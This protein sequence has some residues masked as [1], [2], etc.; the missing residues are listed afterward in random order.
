MLPTLLHALAP[1][2]HPHAHSWRWW[3]WTPEASC[4]PC[5]LLRP[6]SSGSDLSGKPC[7]CQRGGP[8]LRGLLHALCLVWGSSGLTH[9]PLDSR[10]PTAW[11]RAGGRLQGT[12]DLQQSL[13]T[14]C[15]CPEAFSEPEHG[16][17]CG[18]LPPES[19]LRV[20]LP[21]SHLGSLSSLSPTGKKMCPMS[22]VPGH[23]QSVSKSS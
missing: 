3:A 11:K 5:G 8:E 22:C 14:P 13:L 12:T 15:L 7:P 20:W 18:D 9:M 21:E 19:P 23:I 16:L 2:G 1:G 4:S 17:Q 10:V 6:L